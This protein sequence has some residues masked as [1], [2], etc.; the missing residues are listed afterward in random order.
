MYELIGDR[1]ILDTNITRKRS[2]GFIIQFILKIMKMK[3]WI[4]SEPLN[5]KRKLMNLINFYRG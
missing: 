5:I 2:W 1:E 3:M 4:C